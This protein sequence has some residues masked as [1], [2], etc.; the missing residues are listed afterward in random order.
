MAEHQGGNKCLE[1]A[2]FQTRLVMPLASSSMAFSARL[3]FVCSY[4]Y[5]ETEQETLSHKVK[6][7]IQ[8]GFHHN[9]DNNPDHRS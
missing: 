4:W 8:A 7:V 5:E 2:T 1:Q 3:D 6:S 9:I